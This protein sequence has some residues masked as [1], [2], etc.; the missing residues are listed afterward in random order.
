MM[1]KTQL[2]KTLC[3]S[4]MGRKTL[5]RLITDLKKS[6]QIDQRKMAAGKGKATSVLVYLR[7]R[8]LRRRRK[9]SKRSGSRDSGPGFLHCATC[10]RLTEQKR[11][12]HKIEFRK[13]EKPGQ[14]FDNPLYMV[15]T[16]KCTECGQLNKEYATKYEPTEGESSWRR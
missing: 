8:P 15:I 9:G 6:G 14:F 10:N 4:T 7:D 13:P 3:P 11:M 12:H 5:N 1:P 2:E 16:Y